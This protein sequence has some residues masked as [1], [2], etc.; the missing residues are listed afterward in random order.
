MLFKQLSSS[1]VAR[2][3]AAANSSQRLDYNFTRPATLPTTSYNAVGLSRYPPAGKPDGVMGLSAA[4]PP[5]Y[6]EV[7]AEKDVY[8]VQLPPPYPG[9]QPSDTGTAAAR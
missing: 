6:A 4:E 2:S 9:L 8:A 1:S 7:E 5:S 3:A